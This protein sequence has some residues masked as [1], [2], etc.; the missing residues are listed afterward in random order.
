MYKILFL[1]TWFLST[2]LEYCYVYTYKL[3]FKFSSP[4]YTIHSTTLH[5]HTVFG[6]YLLFVWHMSEPLFH[7]YLPS[8]KYNWLS[9]NFQSVYQT[10]CSLPTTSLSSIKSI[11]FPFVDAFNLFLVVLLILY[12]TSKVKIKWQK[13]ISNDN[14]VINNCRLGK[15]TKDSMMEINM[16]TLSS[17]YVKNSD[18]WKDEYH[19]VKVQSQSQP[20]KHDSRKCVW[21]K[22]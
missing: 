3:L 15:I 1:G 20:Y 12:Q 17:D 6:H 11:T 19:Q 18:S 2:W 8:V 7:L 22:R 9:N 4:D 21:F 14:F 5:L 16:Q 10:H 13:K